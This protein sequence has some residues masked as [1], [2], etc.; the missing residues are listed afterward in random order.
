MRFLITGTAGFIGFH[1]AQRLLAD[2]HAV[3]G[4][5][6]ITPYYDQSLKRARLAR[7]VGAA[8]FT[9]H[10]LMRKKSGRLREIVAPPAPEIVAHLAAK[11]GVRYSIE[12]P[13]A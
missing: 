4:I 7:L 1:L 3:T 11:A 2:G 10:K 5:D 6:G 8:Q 12:N 13:R 9:A